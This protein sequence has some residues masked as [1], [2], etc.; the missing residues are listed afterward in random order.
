MSASLTWRRF[1][2]VIWSGQDLAQGITVYPLVGVTRADYQIE[3]VVAGNVAGLGAPY[4]V[5]A[6]GRTGYNQPLEIMNPRLVRFS[7]RFQF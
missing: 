2:D 3:G 1:N 4:D 6:S 5:T 7:V